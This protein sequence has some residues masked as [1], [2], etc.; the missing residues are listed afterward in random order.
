MT[1]ERAILLVQCPDR[2]GIVAAISS[3]L[4]RHGANITDFDQ[5]TSEDDAGIYFTR[6]E[7]QIGRIDLPLREL[8]AAFALDVA[9]PFAMEWRLSL[10]GQRKK[11]AVLVS[12]HD[13]ALL[14]VLWAWKRGDLRADVTS[15]VSNH[16]DLRSAVEPFGVP[17]SHVPNTRERRREA[18]AEMARALD[19]NDLVVLARYMQIVSPELVAR[20]PNRIINI[21]H[22]FLPAFAGADPYRQAYERGVKIVGATAHYVTA[23]LD[24]G[25]IIEQDVGRVTHRDSVDDLKALGRDLER[26]V[27]VRAVRWHCEDRVLV[28]GNKTVVFA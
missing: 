4:F 28:H 24:A 17:F 12:R 7:F 19:G 15:V 20:W 11:V 26:R 3:F 22:S 1:E 5:H 16:P 8:E 9:K 10:S 18:E 25:P 27:L 13:H 14:E 21:H 23:D 2:P 6:L